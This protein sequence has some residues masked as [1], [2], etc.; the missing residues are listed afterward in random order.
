MFGCRLN[1]WGSV[2]GIA[3]CASI[4]GANCAIAQIS[5]DGILPINS[6]V[7]KQVP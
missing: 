1:H 4:S 7:N 3:M 2:L 5:S 6:N